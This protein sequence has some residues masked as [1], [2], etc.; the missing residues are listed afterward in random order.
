MQ[1]LKIGLSNRSKIIVCILLLTVFVGG[2]YYAFRPKLAEHDV[3]IRFYYVRRSC[4]EEKWWK[5]ETCS[6]WRTVAIV[7]A[8]GDYQEMENT[9]MDINSQPRLLFENLNDGVSTN[10]VYFVFKGDL[11]IN[12]EKEFMFQVKE[13][14]TEPF[15][16]KLDLD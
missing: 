14:Y 13:G 1:S 16:G 4:D 6:R 5:V 10:Q 2:I 8:E 15:T 11:R 3:T 7:K 12:E 9:Y